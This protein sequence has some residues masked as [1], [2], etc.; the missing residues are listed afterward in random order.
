M[1]IVVLVGLLVVVAYLLWRS[2]QIVP[3]G[4]VGLVERL[5]RHR[6][7]LPAGLHVVLPL[8]DQMPRV[9]PLGPQTVSLVEEP[10]VTEDGWVSTGTLTAGYEVIDPVAASYA[11]TDHREALTLQLRHSARELVGGYDLGRVLLVTADLE[12]ELRLRLGAPAH[13]WG[14]R[15]DH[16]AVQLVAPPAWSGAQPDEAS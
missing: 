4:H 3:A 1:L 9:M 11:V 12:H 8:V 10:L 7:T 16:V 13:P 14:L 2:V 15:V 6:A 5:G